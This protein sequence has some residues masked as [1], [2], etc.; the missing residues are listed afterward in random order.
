MEL[1]MLQ[2]R[3]EYHRDTLPLTEI[4]TGDVGI[5][6]PIPTLDWMQFGAIVGDG[7]GGV[8]GAMKSLQ[9]LSIIIL[10]LGRRCCCGFRVF[11]FLRYFVSS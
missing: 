7:R 10:I 1:A 9:Q 11:R 5:P 8:S 2:F 6:I 3:P 4:D